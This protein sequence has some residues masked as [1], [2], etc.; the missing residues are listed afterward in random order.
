MTN[1]YFKLILRQLQNIADVLA[2][3]SRLLIEDTAVFS[4]FFLAVYIY[5]PYSKTCIFKLNMHCLFW[6]K[7]FC[8]QYMV[9]QNEAL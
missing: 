7:P 5:L 1:S 2:F 9:V 4:P 6:T 3:C 8:K